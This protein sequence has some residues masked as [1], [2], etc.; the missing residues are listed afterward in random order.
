MG[1]S[2]NI[3]IYY[4]PYDPAIS[5]LGIYSREIKNTYPQKNLHMDV[6]TSFVLFVCFHDNP[7]LE[8]IQV[9]IVKRTENCGIFI[10]WNSIQQL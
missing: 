7:D 4:T 6:Y 2:Q 9:I 3:N 5:L 8:I 1:Y 10:Q